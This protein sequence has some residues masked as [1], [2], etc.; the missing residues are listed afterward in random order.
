MYQF[1]VVLDDLLRKDS[2]PARRFIYSVVSVP[3]SLL[4]VEAEYSCAL[5]KLEDYTYGEFSV[6]RFQELCGGDWSSNYWEISEAA[7]KYLLSFLSRGVFYIGYEMPPW[8]VNILEREGLS[9][10]D[11]RLSPLRFARD[12]YIVLR[13]SNVNRLNIRKNWLVKQ[14]EVTLEAGLVKA[15][16]SHNMP[17]INALECDKKTA[18]FFGQTPGDASLLSSNGKLLKVADYEAEICESAKDSKL[19]YKRHPYAGSHGD[20]EVKELQR[21]VGY[22]PLEIRHDVYTCLASHYD[23]SVLSIASGVCLEAPYFGKNATCL[24]QPICDPF[25]EASVHVRFIDFYCPSMWGVMFGMNV[26]EALALPSL[27]IGPD[28]LMRRFHN[29]WWGYSD[30]IIENDSFWYR[31]VAKSVYRATKRIFSF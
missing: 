4:T 13:G 24:Y 1:A 7:D 19:V 22:R 16:V 26:D 21:I 31:A 20:R 9:W 15:A 27:P 18:V 3:L 28:S 17:K 11:I 14:G 30:F 6:S 23:H 2:I 12:M 8:L 5:T 25:A 10:V 29:A